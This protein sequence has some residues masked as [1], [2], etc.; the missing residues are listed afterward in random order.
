[1]CAMPERV[2]HLSAVIEIEASNK[3]LSF[4]G[5]P[6]AEGRWGNAGFYR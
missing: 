1:M 6:H 4:L 5:R 3:N 2:V